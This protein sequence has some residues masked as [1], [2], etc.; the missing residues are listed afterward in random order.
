MLLGEM[1][2][3]N[4]LPINETDEDLYSEKNSRE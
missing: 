1:E 2:G 3:T 4:P